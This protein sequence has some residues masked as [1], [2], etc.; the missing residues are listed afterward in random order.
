MKISR[1]LGALVIVAAALLVAPGAASAT[2]VAPKL[3]IGEDFPDPEVDQFGSTFY[4]Y[5]TSSG[6]GRTPYATASAPTGP[7]TIRGDALPT[8]PSWAGSGGFWAPDVSQRADGKYLMYFTGPSVA[9]GRMCIGAALSSSPTGPFTPTSSQPLVCNA[10]EGGD[11]DPSSFVDGSSRYLLYKNDGNAIGQPAIIWLQPVAA[12]G[13][14]FTGGRV[15]LLRNNQASEQGVI[16]APRLVKRPSQYVLFY[17]AGV[18]TTGNYQTS[19][20]VSGSLAGPYTRAYRPLLTTASLNNA[21]NGP[22]GEDIS[23]S[24]IFFHGHL[25]TG[26]RGMYVAS[27]GWANDYPVVRGSRVRYEGERGT[28]NDCVVRTGAANASQ[29]AVAAKIDN[30]D[31]WVQLSVFAPVAGSYTVYIGYAAGYG[32]AQHILTVNGGAAQVV[33]YPDHGWDNWTQVPVNVTLQAGFNTVR[34]QHLT[35]WAEIDYVEVA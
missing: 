25:S 34:L 7:W 26:G 21:V 12:D 4:A 27:L 22:G 6:H 5:S 15:E 18:Y 31:S 33:N 8:K 11:I 10:G 20:A 16:E 13:V 28:L 29:G 2:T 14:T 24:Y 9:T 23:G 1:A 32:D 19:Y 17:S 35:K 30:A 3:V